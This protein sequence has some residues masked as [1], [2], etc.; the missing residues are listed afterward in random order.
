MRWATRSGARTPQMD[1]SHWQKY[2]TPRANGFCSNSPVHQRWHRADLP[3][4]SKKSAARPRTSRGKFS[5]MH[6]SNRREQGVDLFHDSRRRALLRFVLMT[7]NRMTGIV[8]RGGSIIAK[9]RALASP[10]KFSLHALLDDICDIAGPPTTFLFPFGDGLRPG[11]IADA[12]DQAQFFRTQGAGRI[13]RAR[14]G[15]GRSSHER[16]PAGHV[17]MH[18]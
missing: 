2:S 13:D 16:R 14:L 5:A 10:G 15:E 6:L 4:R 1:L 17:P 12:N 7:A 18:S 11:S 3:V 9:W 8:W